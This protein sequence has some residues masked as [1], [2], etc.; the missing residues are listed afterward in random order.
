MLVTYLGEDLLPLFCTEKRNPCNINT[1]NTE[2]DCFEFVKSLK[3][4]GAA[5]KSRNSLFGHFFFHSNRSSFW[6]NI[7]CATHL[8]IPRSWGFGRYCNESQMDNTT[9]LYYIR[10][11]LTSMLYDRG[12]LVP[13]QL[14]EETI[15]EFKSKFADSPKYVF[16]VVIN[17]RCITFRSMC[18]VSIWEF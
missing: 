7:L 15:E 16:I 9:K 10:K 14:R 5:E 6:V 4:K 2:A 12:Y 1:M 18:D 11:T 8:F 3:C 13:Q 17:D